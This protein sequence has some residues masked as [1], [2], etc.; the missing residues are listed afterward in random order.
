ML[1]ETSMLY[2]GDGD[3]FEKV[4]ADYVYYIYNETRRLDIQ[5]FIWYTLPDSGW[6]HSGLMKGDIFK[7][8]GINFASYDD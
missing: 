7:P 2:R 3:Y 5:A 4:Q 1:T 8:A 6:N